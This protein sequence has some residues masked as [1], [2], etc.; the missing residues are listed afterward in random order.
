MIIKSL[1]FY[2]TK[3]QAQYDFYII[4]LGFTQYERSN[5]RFS[6]HVGHTHVVIQEDLE[7]QLNPI[8]FAFAL[9]NIGIVEVYH[10][11]KHKVELIPN[12][13]N[14]RVIIDFPAWKAQ[15]LYFFDA[16]Y[17]VVEFILRKR[18]LKKMNSMFSVD[19]I[20]SICEVGMPV[21]NCTHVAKSLKEKLCLEEYMG[22]SDHFIPIGDDDGLFIMVEE[23]VKK[24][25]PVNQLVQAA[26]L[27][28]VVGIQERVYEVSC[29]K[30]EIDIK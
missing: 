15:S 3:L 5:N 12:Q 17:N 28:V 30:E 9:Q 11:L 2:T 16:D 6:F 8:H 19:N 10:F 13:R 22:A 18:D 29:E 4:E 21:K 7:S 20:S 27:E 14:G 25:F 23:G 1:E 26:K 24:W